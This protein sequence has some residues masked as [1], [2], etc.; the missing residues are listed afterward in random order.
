MLQAFSPAGQTVALSIGATATNATVS[1]LVPVRS[2]YVTNL[3]TAPIQLRFDPIQ[4]QTAVFA[5][6]GSPTLGPVIGN[7][8]D[9]II[10][11]PIAL[12]TATQNGM[13]YNC[14]FSGISNTTTQSLV[15]ITPV[16]VDGNFRA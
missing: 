4:Q 1:S 13:V 8:D 10:N 14:Y 11:I 16:V 3:G 15:Y 2:Y 7:Q 6:P 9:F 12:T 5:T